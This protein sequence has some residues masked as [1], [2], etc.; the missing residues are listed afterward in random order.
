MRLVADL[1]ADLPAAV[2]IVMHLAPNGN[3][4]L[5]Y[6]L[7]RAGRL[8]VTVAEDHAR[9]SHGQ[10]YVAP[11]DHHVLVHRGH[12][13][14]VRGPRENMFR[15]AIDPLFRSAAYSYGPRVVGVVLTGSL[16]DGTAGLVTIK[17]FGGLAVVQDPH[18]ALF[19]GMPTNALRSVEVDY[20]L[21]LA[22]IG[23]T[24]SR[25]GRD[26]ASSREVPHVSDENTADYER[27]VAELDL[28]AIEQDDRPGT[29]SE[30]ACPECG[31][32]LWEVKD[33]TLVRFRCRVGHAF[34]GESLM[35]AQ[36]TGLEDALWSALRALEEKLSL[37]QRLAERA[38]T[39][40]QSRAASRFEE[41]A[42]T[43]EEHAE[44]LRRL[45]LDS[46]YFRLI[47]EEEAGG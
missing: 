36:T 25:L 37:A 42:R 1:P 4:A 3:S 31:G 40:R 32:V 44:T 22:E 10:V 28:S 47:D 11:P 29:P 34:S 26:P 17:R 21:P 46:N 23:A 5:P 43:A 19:P 45:L 16:D 9:I 39:N 7:G 38:H 12:L 30:F 6:I 24:L 27:R 33:G 35:A 15:P 20:R 13:R 41:Q 2:I 8:P 14:V 18:D